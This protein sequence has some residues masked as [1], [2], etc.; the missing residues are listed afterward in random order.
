MKC[1]EQG[2][3][4]IFGRVMLQGDAAKRVSAGV[5]VITGPPISSL[6]GAYLHRGQLEGSPGQKKG[7]ALMH[8]HF[9]IAS[10]FLLSLWPKQVTCPG[11]DS[12]GEK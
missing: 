11:P 4:S 10:S 7:Q 8:K 3:K 12:S 2:R 5:M 1:F 9:S 6:V